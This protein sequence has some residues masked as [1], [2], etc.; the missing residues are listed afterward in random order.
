[1]AVSTDNQL[2]VLYL[3][4]TATY[5]TTPSNTLNLF[6]IKNTFFTMEVKTYKTKR[7]CV[8]KKKI[9]CVRAF[10]FCKESLCAILNGQL[11]IRNAQRMVFTQMYLLCVAET[12]TGPYFHQL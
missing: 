11:T 7:F 6:F 3:I 4:C 12:G 5:V 1:M 10:Y 2:G 8:R 9:I